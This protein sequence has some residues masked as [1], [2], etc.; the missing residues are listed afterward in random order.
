MGYSRLELLQYLRRRRKLT[1]CA[2][3]ALAVVLL[4]AYGLRVHR[5][6]ALETQLPPTR[7]A[8]AE[9]AGQVADMPPVPDRGRPPLH[10][11]EMRA[12]AAR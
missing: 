3:V 6:A 4:A 7:Q 8:P 12:A 1:A 11:Y 2:A 9:L 10:D 5:L